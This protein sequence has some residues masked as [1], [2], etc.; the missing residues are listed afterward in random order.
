LADFHSFEKN[1]GAVLQ[2]K[3]CSNFEKLPKKGN[4]CCLI[5]F[6]ILI[7]TYFQLRSVEQVR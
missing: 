6:Q 5:I 4:L 1:F 2:E 3:T 7:N